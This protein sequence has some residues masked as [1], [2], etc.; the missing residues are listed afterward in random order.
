[1]KDVVARATI[2][3]STF[4]NTGFIHLKDNEIEGIFTLDYIKILLT[5]KNIILDATENSIELNKVSCFSTT[6]YNTYQG[7]YTYDDL[8]IPETYS[9][10][11]ENN[12][13]LTLSI[14]SIIYDLELKS[15]ILES[16][17]KHRC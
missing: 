15:A 7:S 17:N 1:M 4:F 2:E 10:Y 8:Y 5:G 9:L 13:P 16:I 14:E 12:N 11:D 6:K 3:T